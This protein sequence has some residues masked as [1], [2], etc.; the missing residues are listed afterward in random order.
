MSSSLLSEARYHEFLASVNTVSSNLTKDFNRLTREEFLLKYGHLR[1]GTYDILSKRYDENADVYFDWNNTYET[2]GTFEKFEL[3]THESDLINR[4]L[5][6]NGF[7]VNAQYLLRFIQEAIEAREFGKFVFTKSL[8]DCF[9]WIEKLG[10]KLGFSREEMS[11]VDI[12]EILK[13]Y[14]SSF[15]A[16]LAI[17]HAIEIGKK[18]HQLASRILLPSLITTKEQTYHYALMFEQANFITTKRIS[19]KVVKLDNNKTQDLS[20]AIVFI[21]AADPGYD[22]I[23]SKGIGG[24]ITKYGGCNSH[25]AIRANEQNIAAIVGAGEVL[26][27]RWINAQNITIDCANKK[28]DVL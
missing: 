23:F 7:S 12:Q 28:V 15:S 11:Y 24:F 16:E 19:G 26:F 6:L 18:E 25:M 17:K 21:E 3:M 27:N 10:K 22:W 20:G 8:S 4:Q 13:L 14:S 5:A 9:L 2:E 1:P